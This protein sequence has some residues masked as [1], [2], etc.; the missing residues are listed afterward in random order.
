MLQKTYPS[1][2][3][4][5]PYIYFAF[6]EADS[7]K[8]EKILRILLQRGCR[9]WY[10]TGPSGSS[11][12]LLRRQEHASKADLTMLYLSAAACADSDIKNSVLVNQSAGRNILCLD[13]DGEDRRL[14]MGLYENVPNI[15]LYEMRSSDDIESAIIHAEGFSQKM[16]GEPVSISG[17]VVGK[18]SL[19]LCILAVILA[20]VCFAGYR[21]FVKYS[22]DIPDEVEIADQAI[23]SALK[24]S[25]NGGAVTENLLSQITYLKLEELPE[26]WDDLVHMPS[27]ERISIPQQSL[28]GDGSLPDGNYTIELR[29]GVS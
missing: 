7:R 21:Y 22:A 9:V 8:A 14:M 26:N 29:G 20:A 28:L 17:S 1:Y 23:L 15:P 19:L 25:V 4:T 27:L 13:T 3:G 18:L 16:I 10:C 11:D 12:E 5:E 24:E 6:A 2:E